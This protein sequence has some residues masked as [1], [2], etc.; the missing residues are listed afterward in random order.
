MPIV[1]G[2]G[3]PQGR[4]PRRADRVPAALSG[5]LA[6]AFSGALSLVLPTWCAGCD[7]PD[8]GLCP[9]CRALL[10]PDVTARTIHDLVVR[11]A[12]PFAGV[13]ARALR[14][15]KEEGRTGL[16]RA[17]APALAAAVSATLAHAAPGP[18][19]VVPVPTSAAAMRRR[20][21]RVVELIAARGRLHPQRLLY[22]AGSAL[23]QRGLGRAERARNVEG[24]MR[25]RGVDG[26]RVLIVDDVVTTGATLREAE[27]AL[28][29]AGATVV[30]AATVAS[31]PRMRFV[32][33][34]DR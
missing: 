22:T 23:D 33:P 12:L 20:G 16:A 7:A 29:A 2:G 28:T 15:C 26:R 24:T 5:V 14:A 31:T 3:M 8:A 4:A 6:G 34:T 17:L 9:A 25:A 21:F 18:V 19:A 10:R 30:G 13:P 32:T 11:S 27:R 1:Q